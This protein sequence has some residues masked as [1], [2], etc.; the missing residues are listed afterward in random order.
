MHILNLKSYLL[1]TCN[2]KLK[3]LISFQFSFSFLMRNRNIYLPI[4]QRKRET[5]LFFNI[6]CY[7]KS[8]FT[9]RCPS[10]VSVNAMDNLQNSCRFLLQNASKLRAQTGHSLKEIW[11]KSY[12]KYLFLVDIQ[13]PKY[14]KVNSF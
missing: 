5:N 8:L 6:I 10:P 7:S 11:Q 14:L 13:F 4:R 1:S 12:M 9:R 3:H 2:K